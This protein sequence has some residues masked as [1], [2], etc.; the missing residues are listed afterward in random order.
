M[1]FPREVEEV[2]THLISDS[3]VDEIWLI[4]SRADGS[5][6]QTSDWDFLVRSTREPRSVPRRSPNI[7]I[8]WSGPSGATLVEGEDEGLTFEFSD[9]AWKRTSTAEASYVGRRLKD[10]QYGVARDATESVVVRSRQRA[11]LVWQRRPE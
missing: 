4:G 5:G 6:S 2:M 8:L 7:D 11:H 9:L 1:E 10:F 3:T